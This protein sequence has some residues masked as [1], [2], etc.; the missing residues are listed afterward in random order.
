MKAR[1]M[2][3]IQAYEY[4]SERYH[5]AKDLA[6]WIRNLAHAGGSREYRNR[7]LTVARR[8]EV[9]AQRLYNIA[10][11]FRLPKKAA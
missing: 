8:A 10:E 4:W 7:C 2:G 11:S 9:R 3:R 6:N 5:S 1:K